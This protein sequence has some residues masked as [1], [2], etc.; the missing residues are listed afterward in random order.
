MMAEI[1]S[2]K[3]RAGKPAKGR[4]KSEVAAGKTWKDFMGEL[5]VAASAVG[6]T[7]LMFQPGSSATYSVGLFLAIA[8]LLIILHKD[9]ERY[10]PD[11]VKNGRNLLLIGTLL[12]L[13]ILLGRI[14]YL[15]LEGFASGIDFLHHDAVIY[16]LPLATG[17]MLAALLVDV[18]VAIVIATL[19]SLSASIWLKDYSFALYTFVGSITG[20]FMVIQ[21]KKRSAVLRGGLFV[22][23]ASLSSGLAV[24]L[25]KGSIASAL[26]YST[27]IFSLINGVAVVSMVSVALPLFENTFKITT[28]IRLLEL[29]DLNQPLLRNLLLQAPGTYHHSIIVGNLSEAAAEAVGAN[30]LL[31]RVSSYYHDIGKVKMP[32]YFIENQQSIDNRHEKLSTTMSSLIIT[33]HVKEGVELA[34]SQNLPEPILDIIREHHGT[35]LMTY[36]YEKAKSHHEPGTPPVSEDDY[37]YPGPKP[38]SRVSALVMLADAVEAASRVLTDP[39]P[40]RISAL[41]EKITNRIFLDGQLDDCELTLKD[42]QKIKEHFTFIL[43]SI[44]HKRID[45]PGMGLDD[46][47]PQHP[48]GDP[49]S[50]ESTGPQ[51]SKGSRPLRVVKGRG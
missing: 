40:A 20:A 35:A 41:V 19:T 10:R 27:L 44:F 15:L 33:S 26:G 14:F 32:D 11:F 1:R 42:L 16:G 31:A 51:S 17:A 38:Q 50:L 13:N 3:T 24:V 23:L 22:S 21:C 48:E 46:K 39:T 8:L 36:F 47:N 28:D 12:L 6:M 4:E 7:V 5:F 18:H 9:L 34:R 2:K 49:D 25:L 43:T 30:P 37:R 29:L 45:Y